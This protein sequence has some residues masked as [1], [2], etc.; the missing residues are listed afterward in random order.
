MTQPAR[1]STERT[2][3][4][5]RVPIAEE[6]LNVVKRAREIGEV[7]L[8]RSVSHERQSASIDVTRETLRVTRRNGEARAALPEEAAHAFVPEVRRIPVLG[9][10][11]VA[12]RQPFVTGEVVVHRRTVTERQSVTETVRH[13][14]VEPE[15]VTA[16]QE[17]VEPPRQVAA[18]AEKLS[19]VWRDVRDG[20]SR[21]RQRS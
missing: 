11:A 9:E 6:R 4:E 21:G 1:A 15:V 7:L 14:V 16:P 8:R 10:Q 18:P 13:T 2:D 3:D 17:I 12:V 19:S 20:F 5:L